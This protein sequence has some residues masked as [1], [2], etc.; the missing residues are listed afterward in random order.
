MNMSAKSKRF[1]TVQNQSRSREDND[2]DPVFASLVA[3]T[4]AS[5]T[6]GSWIQ[7]S[8]V[9]WGI[10]PRE[11]LRSGLKF[12]MH[13]QLSIERN[14]PQTRMLRKGNYDSVKSENWFLLPSKTLLEKKGQAIL[15]GFSPPHSPDFDNHSWEVY[16][17]GRNY[18]VLQSFTQYI[19]TVTLKYLLRCD[20]GIGRS[21][22]TVGL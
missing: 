8:T 15:E 11:D 22:M 14:L 16:V 1:P 7:C 2:I 5:P 20:C 19:Q 3:K 13:T 9:F 6:H 21:R 12:K 17:R 18:K 10:F 4:I